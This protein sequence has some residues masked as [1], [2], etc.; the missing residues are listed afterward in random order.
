MK[1]SLN[2]AQYYSNVDLTKV[3]KDKLIEK[4]GA[5]LGAVEEVVEWGPRFDGIVVVKVIE[6]EPHTNADKLSVCWIDDGKTVKGMKRNDKG[7]VQVVCGAPNVRAGMLAAWLSPGATVPSTLDKEPFRLD[8]REIRGVVSNGMLAS[9]SELGISDNHAGILEID[10][11]DVGNDLARP[12]TAFKKLYGLDDIVIDIENK[13]FTHRPD[14]FGILGVARELAG[15]QGLSFRSPDWYLDPKRTKY[16]ST[17]LKLT[18]KNPVPKLVPRFMAQVVEDITVGPSPA[19]LQAS[20]T[21]VGLKPINNVV[22]WSNF[23]MHLTAQPTHA[24]DYDKLVALSSTPTLQPRMAIEGEKLKIL[25][26]KTITLTSEDIVIATDKQPV[27][28]AG[29]MGGADTEVD[30]STKTIVIEAATFDMYSVRRSS[31]R[32]GLFTD[33]VA[34]FNKGQSPMQNDRVLADLVYELQIYGAKPT[35]LL[36]DLKSRQVARRDSV[37]VTPSFVN[38]R[39]GVTLSPK[40]ITTLLENVEFKVTPIG[41]QLVVSPPFWRTDI[42]I[43]EDVVEE[44]GRLYGYDKLPV[45]LP[46]RTIKPVK[47]NELLDFKAKVR[48]ILSNSGANEVL[49]YSF[50]H[51]DL[52]EKTGQDVKKAY[53]LSNALSPELQYFR[54]SLTPSLLDKVHPNIKAGTDQFAIFEIGKGHDKDHIEDDLPKELELTTLVFA[55]NDKLSDQSNGAPFYNARIYLDRLGDRLGLHLAYAPVPLDTDFP[56]TAPFDLKRSAF[57]TD[58]RSGIFIGIIGEFKSSVRQNLKLPAIIAGFELGTEDL[59]KAHQA[60]GNQYFP[61]SKYPDVTQDM[62]LR[63]AADLPFQELDKTLANAISE[64]VDV[65][66]MPV[67]R[68]VLAI[69]QKK[70]EEHKNISFRMNVMSYERTLTTQAVNT[71]LDNIADL[72]HQKLSAERV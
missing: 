27:A 36:F 10:P 40:Q 49:T 43:P 31:M 16:S 22:D 39:L 69:Y 38:E 19:W 17:N 44:V 52:F 64:V 11:K 33:A 46:K 7:L 34:R 47:R 54:M 50:V 63:V 32:H 12:G 24:F 21:R 72:L 28:L 48:D 2:L 26:G 56:L 1:V 71:I 13:M 66:T 67:S 53:K 41:K 59:L 8:A 51:N 25:G 42:E 4:V 55:A 70:G 14:C 62:T 58:A 23:Y 37:R 45:E 6:C 30:A 35:S 15:I 20:L 61:L 68:T 57:V 9:P 3:G 5:Q 60:A 29:I 65:T 18:V